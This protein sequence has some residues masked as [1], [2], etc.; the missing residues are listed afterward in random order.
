MLFGLQAM[1]NSLSQDYV[2]EKVYDALIAGCVPIY[3]GAGNIDDLIPHKSAIVDFASLGSPAALQA[4][5]ERLANNDTA[6][7]EK[8][9][10]KD[11]PSSRWSPGECAA[12]LV[13][14]PRMFNL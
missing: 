12:W 4:E 14:R 3:W 2:S 5:L 6:Y 1:E 10:W 11:W 9:A 7:A 8:L 13:G